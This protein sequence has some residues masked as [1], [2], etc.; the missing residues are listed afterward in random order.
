MIPKM[1]E[2]ANTAARKM[3]TPRGHFLW[4]NAETL[5]GFGV[6]NLS[7]GV[8]LFVIMPVEILPSMESI[9]KNNAASGITAIT[10]STKKVLAPDLILQEHTTTIKIA[11]THVSALLKVA[12]ICPE[13]Y[14]KG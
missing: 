6:V 1:A 4:R 11:V 5:E 8:I 13:K 10:G 9:S 3:T 7:L 14:E 12:A 2:A